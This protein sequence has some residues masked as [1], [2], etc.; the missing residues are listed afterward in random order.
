MPK[1]WVEVEKLSDI[2][3][4]HLQSFSHLLLATFKILNDQDFL[5]LK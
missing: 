3:V 4:M 5:S 2:S 1:K